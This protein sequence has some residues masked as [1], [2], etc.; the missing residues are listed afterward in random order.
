MLSNLFLKGN[1]INKYSNKMNNFYKEVIAG[2]FLV[3]SGFATAQAVTLGDGE[4]LFGYYDQHPETLV[5]PFGTDMPLVYDIALKVPGDYA[6]CTLK[7]VLVPLFDTSN[8]TYMSAWASTELPLPSGDSDYVKGDLANKVFSHTG[9]K[10][11]MKE[12]LFDSPVTIPADGLYIGYSLGVGEG[13]AEPVAMVVPNKEATDM[14]RVHISG[15]EYWYDYTYDGA[16]DEYLSSCITAIIGGVKERD[17]A[18]FEPDGK[19]SFVKTAESINIPVRSEGW[20]GVE[21]IDY[22]FTVNGISK[23]GH[24][25][26]P[27]SSQLRTLH[28]WGA[29]DVAKIEVPAIENGGDYKYTLEL[30]QVNGVA[31]T[32]VNTTVSGDVKV[33]DR[34][35]NRTPLI[36]EATST[37]CTWCPRLIYAM[38]VMER[39]YPESVRIVY[40]TPDMG[41]ADPMVAIAGAPWS[42]TGVP[43]VRIDRAIDPED[44]Y[45]KK[46]VGLERGYLD[47]QMAATEVEL[48]GKAAWVDEEA[49]QIS[50]DVEAIFHSEVTNGNY[51]FDFA[52]LQDGMKG[53]GRDW[54]QTN[55]YAGMT[56]E[57]SEPEW[58]I[59][60]KSSSKKYVENMVYNNV[61]ILGGSKDMK[62]MLATIDKNIPEG[63]SVKYT[64][65]FNLSDAK[66]L[67]N[68]IQREGSLIQK[69]E[70]LKVVAM[71]VDKESG[72]IANCVRLTMDP[73]PGVG[74]EGVAASGDIH[75]VGYYDLMGRRVADPEN[76]VYIVRFSDGTSV[77]RVITK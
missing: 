69:K 34:I 60:G 36:E 5:E 50:V 8:A 9:T 66:K 19:F 52:L 57:Y 53:E 71:V 49:T 21:S 67:V 75:I 46:T 17:N 12:V 11:E 3:F 47:R 13:V 10:F 2:A 7:G 56:N 44:G 32:A 63:G 51:R 73:V 23:E 58:G 40:H 27:A 6:G 35:T 1:N 54:C 68:P 26:F 55:G 74:I 38:E 29:K 28:Q 20:N 43:S 65:V 64:H 31:N 30:K 77:K 33:Y 42:Y 16:M 14:F 48:T 18:Y 76:G 15:W 39:L 22:V 4:M 45:D 24:Y 37:Y 25:E 59:F 41:Y 70:N 61:F 72:E 62:G